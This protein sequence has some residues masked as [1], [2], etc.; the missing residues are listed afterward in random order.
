MQLVSLCV[1]Y[2]P[3]IEESSPY[4]FFQRWPA[5]QKEIRGADVIHL[6]EVHTSFLP[7][8]EEFAQ[9]EEYIMLQCLYHVPRQTILVTLLRGPLY[10]SH[11]VH[12]APDTYAKA[13]STTVRWRDT[14]CTLF[15]MHLPLDIKC[16]GE[17]MAAT[18]AFVEAA[19]AIENSI[20][21]GDWNT[22][23][24]RYD[25]GQLEFART[26]GEVVPWDFGGAPE[27]TF[28]G[29]PHEEERLQGYNE[30]AILDRLWI[31]PRRGFKVTAAVCQ[32]VFIG[33]MA[34]ADHFPCRVCLE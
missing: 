24:G 31:G 30:S 6:Q 16:V 26:K 3:K 13:L 18:R 15:N 20:I 11:A 1:T 9:R 32:H 22:L 23:P 21:L 34:I 19:A 17:R 14:N 10:M 27:T 2:E 12:A 8:V 4:H 25:V 7:L 29:Y 5:I 33:D 28:W